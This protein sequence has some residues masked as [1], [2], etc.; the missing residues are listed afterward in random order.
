M[1]LSRYP[2]GEWAPL[3]TEFLRDMENATQTV[4]FSDSIGDCSF[5]PHDDYEWA[6]VL[7]PIPEPPRELTMEETIEDLKRQLAEIKEGPK[8]GSFPPLRFG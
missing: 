6:L 7:P 3:T 5:H 8:V 1:S 4:V 2:V